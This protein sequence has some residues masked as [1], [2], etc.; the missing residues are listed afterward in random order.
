MTESP[1]SRYIGIVRRA[2]DRA[3]ERGT[4][5]AQRGRSGT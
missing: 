1:S 4:R 2:R 3:I 5:K